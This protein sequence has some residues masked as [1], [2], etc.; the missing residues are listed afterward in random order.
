MRKLGIAALAALTLAGAFAVSTSGAEARGWRGGHHG[1]YH[2][3]RGFGVG[4]GIAT[5]LALGAIGSGYYYGGYGPGYYGDGCI[6][7]R[8]VGHTAYGRPLVRP[9]NVCY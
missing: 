6:R 2:G 8:V 9:V 1:Y 7:N 4:A 5:G 3:G